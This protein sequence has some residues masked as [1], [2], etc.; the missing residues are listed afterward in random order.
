M[1]YD[2]YFRKKTPQGYAETD[3]CDANITYNLRDMIVASTSLPWKNCVNNGSVNNIMPYIITGYNNLITAPE[4]YVKYNSPNGWGTVEGLTR[5]FYDII[6]A[7]E[8]AAKDMEPEEL[9]KLTFWI[10]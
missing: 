3:Y 4:E 7:Y 2:I 8:N 1:S 6:K 5:F 9:D 10:C